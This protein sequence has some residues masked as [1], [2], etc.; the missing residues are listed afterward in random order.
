MEN[1]PSTKRLI[2]A[3]AY[4]P[5]EAAHFLRLPAGTVRAWSFGQRYRVG[6][7]WKRFKPVIETADSNA[8]FL[9]FVNLV[10]LHVLGAIRRVHDV[11]LPKLRSAVEY[12]RN[13]LKTAHPLANQDF[14]TDG[15]NLFVEAFGHIINAS[16]GGQVAF[17]SLIEAHLLRIER[18]SRGIPI[19]LYP[20]TRKTELDQPRVVVIDPRVA[21]G[22][23]A[24]RN[25][26][27]PTSILAERFDAGESL[28]SIARDYDKR[29]SDIEEALRYERQAA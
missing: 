23:P 13:H 3:P 10:E 7:V 11:P 15:I 12:V 29:V 1:K 9:S 19:R 25:T 14:H 5:S 21:F 2:D 20:F 22:K 6:D 18:D 24:L 26:G 27:I 17:R 4:T 8:G 16:K 28:E